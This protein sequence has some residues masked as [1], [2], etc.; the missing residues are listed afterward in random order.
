MATEIVNFCAACGNRLVG[1]PY[2]P[3]CG[4]AVAVTAPTSAPP[5]TRAPAV[6]GLAIAS[7]VLGI[8]WLYWIGSILALFFGHYAQRQI[9][10]SEGAQTGRGMATAGIVLGWSGVVV[11][12]VLIAVSLALTVTE[13]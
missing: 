1:G 2:C 13:N 8:L 11:L 7:L 9:D 6:N 12:C 5:V 3:G 4:K 10:E